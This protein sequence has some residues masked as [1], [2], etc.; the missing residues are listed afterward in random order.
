[1]VNHWIFHFNSINVKT[2]DW[3]RRLISFILVFLL[4]NLSLIFFFFQS[5]ATLG[6]RLVVSVSDIRPPSS[7]L[8]SYSDRSKN[9]KIMKKNQRIAAL[10]GYRLLIF[11]VLKMGNFVHF[12]R[13]KAYWSDYNRNANPST[14]C[15]PTGS[16][17]LRN[18]TRY[19]LSRCWVRVVGWATLRNCIQFRKKDKPIF[20]LPSIARPPKI[21]P[22]R[23]SLHMPSLHIYQM[24][25]LHVPNLSH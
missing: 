10:V 21:E 6:S 14:A 16:S 5:K 25:S 24:P 7:S 13:E 1:M 17:L 20:A 4:T 18:I 22:S 9:T 2:L 19:L 23:T 3:N 12:K 11:L 15:L 8:D